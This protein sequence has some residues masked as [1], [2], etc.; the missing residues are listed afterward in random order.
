[1]DGTVGDPQGAAVPG[2]AVRVVNI[3][4]DQTF[5]TSSSDRGEWALT[6]MPAATYRVTVTKPGFKAA[7]VEGVEMNAGVPVTVN[8]MLELGQSSDNVQV[9]GG[10][11]IIQATSASVSSTLTGRQVFELPFATRNAVELLVTQPGTQTPTNP[12]SSTINGLPKGAL[13]VTIDG[14]N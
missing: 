4:T 11:E 1:M 5:G 7:T 2:A 6:A 8:I 12:R 3:S 9:A 14:L 10:A 13:N